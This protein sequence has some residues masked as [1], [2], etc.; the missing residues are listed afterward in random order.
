MLNVKI[1]VL[2]LAMS[3]SLLG[4]VTVKVYVQDLREEITAMENT[5]NKLSDEVQVL[6]AE[7]SNLNRPERIKNLAKQYLQLETI[8][9][10]KIESLSSS[11]NDSEKATFVAV[12]NGI[13]SHAVK[14]R[15]KPRDIVM[16]RHK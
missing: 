15:Y 8:N 5:K 6:N 16:R 9:T 3:F 14:W 12:K 7:W 1:L 13:S 10:N 4:L 2:V 11:N